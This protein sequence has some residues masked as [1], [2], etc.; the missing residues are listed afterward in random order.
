MNWLAIAESVDRPE[1]AGAQCANASE[2][3]NASV[4]ML[5]PKFGAYPSQLRQIPP[6]PT[7][8]RSYRL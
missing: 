7:C 6:W 1:N 8:K 5:P 3:P 4:T 2:S